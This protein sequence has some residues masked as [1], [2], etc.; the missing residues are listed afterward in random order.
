MKWAAILAVSTNGVIGK[1]GTLPWHLPADLKEFKR[2]TL[3]HTIVMGRKTFDSIKKP[4][5]ERHNIVLTRDRNFSAPGIEVAHDWKEL[6][7]RLAKN[8]DLGFIVGGSQLYEEAWKDIQMLYLTFIHQEV[9]G[10]TYFKNL[11]NVATEFKEISRQ[12][13]PAAEGKPAYSFVELE[14]ISR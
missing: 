2:R 14:R 7:A 5:S 1:N 6:K 13:F 3:H 8:A 10:D 4:L 11:S 12:D 9:E